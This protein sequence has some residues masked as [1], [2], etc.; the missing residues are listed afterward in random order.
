MFVAGFAKIM[1]FRE[2][3]TANKIRLTYNG[4]KLEIGGKNI[5]FNS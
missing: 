1:P 2:L 3:F 5:F 4:I